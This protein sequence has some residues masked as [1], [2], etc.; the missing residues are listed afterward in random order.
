[1]YKALLVAA[2]ASV[3]LSV[4]APLPASSQEG[5]QVRIEALDPGQFPTVRATVTVLDGAGR[6]VVGLPPE[7]FQAS[8]GGQALLLQEVASATDQGLG[9][10]VVLAFDTS[11]SMAG[12]PMQQARAAGKALVDQLGPADN[13]EIVA[14]NDNVQTLQPFTADRQALTLAIDSLLAGGNTAL[15]EAVT[16]SVELAGQSNLPRRAVVILSD[17]QDYGSLSA[18]TREG[19]LASAQ[20]GNVP[21]F[22]VGLG[23]V[24]QPYLQE[25]ANA[26]R[27]QLTLAP[28]PEALSGLYSAI[29]TILRHQYLL[30][31]DA[32]SL[33]QG[34]TALLRVTVSHSGSVA[35]AEVPLPL[36]AAPAPPP[37]VEPPPRLPP[38]PVPEP[39]AEGSGSGL[40]ALVLPVA[41][42]AGV[43]L[44]GGFFWWRRRRGH[45]ALEE[46]EL[47]DLPTSP[48]GAGPSLAA[49]QAPATPPI[50]APASLLLLAPGGGRQTYAIGESPLTIGFTS[51][52]NV[53]LPN[54]VAGSWE[55]V[56]VW[57][58]EGHYMLHNLSRRGSVSVAGRPVNWVVLEEG[59]EIQLGA[60]RLLF[61]IAPHQ[62]SGDA[63]SSNK[64]L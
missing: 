27:G 54:G 19:S 59:D 35:Y 22:V 30:T 44:L 43:A 4:L 26:A 40:L 53:R 23:D 18:V 46:P 51:D 9:I 25:L 50:P 13:V 55:R 10:G 37:P 49:E 47:R 36:P 21:F 32:A 1:M 11:G 14:F 17:G 29:G 57:R 15:Y 48:A 5:I 61:H 24:D 60:C 42:A 63:P 12:Q 58:R 7:S 34:G 39:A 56:R 8:A 52:C 33:G 20:Q 64:V 45:R 41:A 16:R 28:T 38:A 62:T 31:V 2:V 3:A 6:P